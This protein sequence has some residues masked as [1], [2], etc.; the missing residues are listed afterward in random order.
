MRSL[1]SR[2]SSRLRPAGHRRQAAGRARWPPARGEV[3]LPAR[4]RSNKWRSASRATSMSNRSSPS[5]RANSTACSPSCRAVPRVHGAGEATV[6][7]AAPNSPGSARASGRCQHR[8]KQ[9]EGFLVPET[10]HPVAPQRDAE[11]QDP[12]GP[13]WI[14][15]RVLGSAPQ[16][17]LLGVQPGEPPALVRARSGA[18]PPSRRRTGSARSAPR[19]RRRPRP[20]RPRRAVRRRTGGW[21][22][23]AGS[24]GL[25]RPA[26]PRRG[27]CPP[28]S[29]A[30]R[31]RRTPR[32]RRS[33][34]T[35]SAASRS[36]LSANTDRRRSSDCSGPL[37]SE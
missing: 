21:S 2:H 15:G 32:C 8:H 5:W 19:R 12:R 24:A 25:P 28:A 20:R 10:R 13:V 30:D 6:T 9:P 31:R 29:R 3:P 22:P 23:A 1:H 11:T 33:R 14:A 35:A 26:R 18:G 37:S 16:V 27:S 4:R 7:S 17:R 36:K 34:T